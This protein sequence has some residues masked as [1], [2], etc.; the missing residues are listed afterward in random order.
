MTTD[1]LE[2]VPPSL[3]GAVVREFTRVATRRLFCAVAT[4]PESG[5]VAAPLLRLH[6]VS[7]LHEN[8]AWWKSQFV[9][10]GEWACDVPRTRAASSIDY[11]SLPSTARKR[12]VDKT[13]NPMA[14]HAQTT[15]TTPRVTQSDMTPART[16]PP[17]GA[18]RA[19]LQ[20][21]SH[22][23]SKTPRSYEYGR[24]RQLV[25]T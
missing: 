3:V 12:S 25:N 13:G 16:T 23:K 20:G 1:V 21:A 15:D 24:V 5:R 7:A 9:A 17:H 10:A 4:K 22:C 11:Y 18:I 19:T 14:A 2:H 6:N 8:G